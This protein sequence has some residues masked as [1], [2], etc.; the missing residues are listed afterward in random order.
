MAF[1]DESAP[2]SIT[3]KELVKITARWLK[4]NYNSAIKCPIVIAELVTST[5]EIPD[6]IGFRHGHSALYEIKVSRADFL[7]D[8][9]KCH[10]RESD[11]GMGSVRYFVAPKGLIKSD[12]LPEKWGLYE[13]H[14][15]GQ[16]RNVVKGE[17]FEANKEAEIIMLMSVI[18][19]L[20]ISTAVFVDTEPMNKNPGLIPKE[21]G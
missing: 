3:H 15:S 7:S 12:E 21:E 17:R 14:R 5:S 18:R 1:I 20:E 8:K 4:N 2:E 16:I 9:K 19:R 11:R 10:R 6:V 13:Y